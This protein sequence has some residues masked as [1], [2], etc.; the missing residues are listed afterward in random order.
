MVKD[1][2]LSQG[3]R[4][5]IQIRYIYPLG[6]PSWSGQMLGGIVQV[7]KEAYGLRFESC[8]PEFTFGLFVF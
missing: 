1:V 4:K 2:P 3:S 7:R 6:L 8:H 5:D